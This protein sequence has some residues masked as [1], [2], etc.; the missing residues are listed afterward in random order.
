MRRG[1]GGP[2]WAHNTSAYFTAANRSKL[3]LALDLT[4]P[5]DRSLAQQ[6][7]ARADVLVENFRTG[8]LDRFGLDYAAVAATNPRIVYASVTGF[9]STG[10]ADLP[11]YDFVVQAMGGPD[12]HHRRSRG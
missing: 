3:S 8:V 4:D 6:L 10:G 9:G 5:T 2:P 7:A 11:G 12:E 1:T